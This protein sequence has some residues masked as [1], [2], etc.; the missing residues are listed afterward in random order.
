[1]PNELNGFITAN[2]RHIHGRFHRT[3]LIRVRLANRLKVRQHVLRIVLT[4]PPL[5]RSSD[6]DGPRTM[7]LTLFISSDMLKDLDLTFIRA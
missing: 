5:L 7:L 4:G 3:K 6:H 1:M 2:S